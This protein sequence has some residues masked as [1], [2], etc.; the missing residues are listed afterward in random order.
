LST[1]AR[2]KERPIFREPRY[3]LFCRN[4]PEIIGQFE[5]H[6]ML[7]GII[8]H[9]EMTGALDHVWRMR[10]ARYDAVV[11]F[12]TGDHSYWK[13]KCLPFL[14]GAR[15]KVIFNENSDCFFFSW[16]AWISHLSY[17]ASQREGQGAEAQLASHTRAL[18]VPIIKL[19]LLPFRFVWL[20][21]VWL[22][23]RSSVLRISD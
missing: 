11:A 10:R 16:R 5:G 19:T 9:S 13:I 12:F 6:P 23:L 21:M 15:H 7:S 14:L 20:L 2:L 4:K 17:R 1:L 18:A 22:W 8:T 3:T